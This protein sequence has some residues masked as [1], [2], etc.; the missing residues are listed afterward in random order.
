M[1]MPSVL[2]PPSS[3]AP[4]PVCSRNAAPPSP[5][6]LT[7]GTRT[8]STCVAAYNASNTHPDVRTYCKGDAE[9]GA[10]GRQQGGV[11]GCEG[12]AVSYTHLTLPTIL[13]V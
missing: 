5:S 12:G 3:S 13:L 8:P 10:S 1:P 9:V 7:N 6:P 2:S 11:E 4:R